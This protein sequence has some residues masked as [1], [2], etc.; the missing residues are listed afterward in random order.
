MKSYLVPLE[1]LNLQNNGYHLLVEVIIYNQPYYMVLD[2]GASK[3]VFDKTGLEKHISTED[4]LNSD[5]VS[6][7]LGTNAMESFLIHLPVLQIGKL[8]LSNFEAAVLD[9]SSISAAYQF[10]ELPPVIGVLGGDILQQY[11]ALIDY[12]KLQLKL[13]LKDANLT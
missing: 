10:L 13:R 3:T 4:L 1:L 5:K 6:T 12:Q 2:T 11:D 8:K 9:L 7:G